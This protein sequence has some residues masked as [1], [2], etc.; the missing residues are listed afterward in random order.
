MVNVGDEA[1]PDNPAANCLVCDDCG[2]LFNSVDF[3]QLHAV[4]SGHEN[5]SESKE[6]MKLMTD[7]EKAQRLA[8]LKVKLQE[9]RKL[10]AIKAEEEQRRND[11]IRR[12]ATKDT[13][14]MKRELEEKQALKAAQERLREK[15]EEK[16]LRERI[17]QQIAEDRQ[18]MKEKAAQEKRL[19]EGKPLVME[20]AKPLVAQTTSS[21]TDSVRLQIRLPDGKSLRESLP[22][23]MTLRKLLEL[24]QEKTGFGLGMYGLMIPLPPRDFDGDSEADST[25]ASL[26]LCP[27]A[28]LVLR[29]L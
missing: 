22:S 20:S 3:A 17:K 26:G 21:I 5:F 4:K 12:K 18:R 11:Q 2:K 6:Q 7:E 29:R 9:K 23:S 1:Q 28:S 14:E 10:D 19:A 24:V 16:Q 25:L 27:S 13:M 15:Q 8:E